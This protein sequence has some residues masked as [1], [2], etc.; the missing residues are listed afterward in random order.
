MLAFSPALIASPSQ[1][2]QR[3][4]SSIASVR[5]AITLT[6]QNRQ[7]LQRSLQKIE[8]QAGQLAKTMRTTNIAL[9]KERKQL[10]QLQQQEKRSQQKLQQEQN[11]LAKQL[12]AAY[13]LGHQPYLKIL[14][15]Q[16]N[17]E[18]VSRLLVYYRYIAQGE[19][20]T[21]KQIQTTLAVIAH[22]EQAIKQKTQKLLTLK[23][24]QQ[25]QKQNLDTM[26]KKRRKLMHAIK[27]Q[28]RNK[29]AR[30]T[31]LITNKQQLEQT[32]DQLSRQRWH[33]ART[34]FTKW[35]GKLRWPTQGK[36]VN[37]FGTKIDKSELRWSGVLI[38]APLGRPVYAIAPGKV[39]FA[40]WL[41]GYGLLLIVSHGKG[42][43]TL[44]GRNNSLYKQV[45]DRV[46]AGDLI[47][48]VGESGGFRAPAL[49]FA[50]RHNNK[51][52]NPASWLR[53]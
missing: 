9:K 13:I 43:I 15:S 47:A 30:L 35:R 44:Y 17:S 22:D 51:P 23:I 42:Y 4:N 1:Q 48:R 26:L 27:Q 19:T 7:A 25:Q 28:L 38:K 37:R 46:R 21:L 11:T 40:K 45:G 50:I 34:R 20:Q 8:T 18:Q 14:F 39:I 33:T 12:K 41:A 24:Q 29:R 31:T 32:L 16:E 3:I 6:Q 52:L 53:S 10:S 2:L 49:Y 5:K 36:M